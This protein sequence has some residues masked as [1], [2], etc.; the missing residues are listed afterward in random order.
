LCILDDAVVARLFSNELWPIVMKFALYTD[1]D[2]TDA[3]AAAD[4]IRRISVYRRI[5]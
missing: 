2:A 3:A 5:R 1:D 4:V